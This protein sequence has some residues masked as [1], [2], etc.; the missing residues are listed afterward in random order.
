[1]SLAND[2]LTDNFQRIQRY[3]FFINVRKTDILCRFYDQLIALHQSLVVKIQ[4]LRTDDK[5]H[6]G[7]K[8][9]KKLNLHCQ[10]EDSDDDTFNDIAQLFQ[11]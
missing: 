2:R 10:N 4:V 11:T 3:D 7:T 1:M 5:N 6:S 9:K 8:V